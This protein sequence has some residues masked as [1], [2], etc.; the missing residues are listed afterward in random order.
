MLSHP[1]LPETL[2]TTHSL[3]LRPC[4]ALI[5]LHW[6]C[7]HGHRLLGQALRLS[8]GIFPGPPCSWM[9]VELPRGWGFRPGYTFPSCVFWKNQQLGEQTCGLA[10]WAGFSPTPCPSWGSGR[11]AWGGVTVAATV[12]LL[13]CGCEGGSH[14]LL[15]LLISA[16][17]LC[18]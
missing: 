9:P 17:Q 3:R 8:P 4:R 18:A 6:V 2:P 13:L 5:L 12:C 1:K 10:N 11:T 15:L 7:A 14:S 16:P